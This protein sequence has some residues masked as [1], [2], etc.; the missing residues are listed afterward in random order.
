M[1]T[2]EE[3]EEEVVWLRRDEVNQE[4]LLKRDKDTSPINP[5]NYKNMSF[6]DIAPAD[7]GSEDSSSAIWEQ[8]AK[9]RKVRKGILKKHHGEK[10]KKRRRKGP[11]YKGGTK[12][13]D[14]SNEQ[15][16]R[17]KQESLEMAVIE[18][19]RKEQALALRKEVVV[20]WQTIATV[21]D[22]LL[23]W[24]FFF[25]TVIAYL[26]ILVFVPWTK[27]EFPNDLP[28]IHA[29]IKTSPHTQGI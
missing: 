3:E 12:K 19:C 14:R 2:E 22:R 5:E 21:V 25:A 24:L 17:Q 29:F 28:A 15:K 20:E 27:P 6:E 13:Q 26:V 1:D 11:S 23:F 7:E 18:T 8:S 9:G 10:S 4:P 16:Q